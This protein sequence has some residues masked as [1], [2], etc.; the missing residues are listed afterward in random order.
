MEWT[1]WNSIIFAMSMV[2]QICDTD[3]VAF[4]QAQE[5]RS[6]RFIAW[7][8]S[9]LLMRTANLKQKETRQKDRRTDMIF[10]MGFIQ[11]IAQNESNAGQRIP[12]SQHVK[13]DREKSHVCEWWLP[14]VLSYQII[15][16]LRFAQIQYWR[17]S[18]APAGSKSPPIQRW[19]AG[20]AHGHLVVWASWKKDVKSAISTCG[21]QHGREE[22]KWEEARKKWAVLVRMRVMQF[23]SRILLRPEKTSYLLVVNGSGLVHRLII[24]EVK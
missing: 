14:N 8:S 4:I 2:L 19:P 9:W 18:R 16:C 22:L 21:C 6:H 11:Y 5:K 12:H 15:Q 23:S 13:K 24:I 1:W 20:L 10:Q 3:V 7:D 17:S